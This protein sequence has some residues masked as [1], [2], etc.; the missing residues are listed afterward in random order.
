MIFTRPGDHLW[1]LAYLFV[2][3]LLALATRSIPPLVIVFA[4]IMAGAFLSTGEGPR[5]FSNAAAFFI[6]VT[7]GPHLPALAAF[8]RRRWTSIFLL[9]AAIALS[10]AGTLGIARLSIAVWQ[11]PLYVAGFLGAAGCVAIFASTRWCAF[12]RYIG[13]RTVRLY[14]LH[15]PFIMFPLGYLRFAGSV[16][17]WPMLGVALVLGFVPPLIISWLTDRYPVLEW[18]FAWNPTGTLFSGSTAKFVH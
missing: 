18:L 12:L 2:Y 6:G 14:V 7:L 10:A 5:F 4:L 11:M 17:P 1:F 3:Y 16:E 9:G 8:V 15:V 13:R